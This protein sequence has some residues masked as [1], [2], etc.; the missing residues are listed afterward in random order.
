[1]K[2]KIQ[3]ATKRNHLTNF[4]GFSW[5]SVSVQRL[6][7]KSDQTKPDHQIFIKRQPRWDT[8]SILRHETARNPPPLNKK[9]N[10]ITID[11]RCHRKWP[12]FKQNQNVVWWFLKCHPF[13]RPCRH[14]WLS[15]HSN[16][17]KFNFTPKNN[18]QQQR[19]RENLKETHYWFLYLWILQTLCDQDKK[20]DTSFRKGV[21]SRVLSTICDKKP[22]R[23]IHTLLCV[24]WNSMEIN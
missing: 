2:I 11:Y 19:N 24:V 22:S 6:V 12:T 1:M 10:W 23:F 20:R 4:I 13:R 18:Q 7:L 5:D 8:P 14:S 15:R 3:Q 21:P 17:R 16:E 9:K